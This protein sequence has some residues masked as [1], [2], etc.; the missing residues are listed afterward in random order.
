MAEKINLWCGFSNV[1][2]HK[3]D[4]KGGLTIS[5]YGHGN[6]REKPEEAWEDA[7]LQESERQAF[8]KKEGVRAIEMTTGI[9]P[10]HFAF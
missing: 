7:L 10:A 6:P 2:Y 9:C 1:M 3:R 4:E 8:L 5:L